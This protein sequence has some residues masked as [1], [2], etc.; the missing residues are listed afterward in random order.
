MSQVLANYTRMADYLSVAQIYLRGNFLLKEPLKREHIKTRLLGHC[1][2]CPDINFAC[3]HL[4]RAIIDYGHN[5][6]EITNWV[7]ESR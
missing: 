2:T 4:N 1:G 3:A 7:W 6:A 5:P